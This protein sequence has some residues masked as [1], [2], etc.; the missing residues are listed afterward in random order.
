L[1]QAFHRNL[2]DL[3]DRWGKPEKAQPLLEQRLDFLRGSSGADSPATAGALA[4]L[5]SNLLAQ[6]K[7]AQAERALR[8][9]LRAREKTQPDEW[10]TFNTRSMLG[11]VLVGQKKYAEAGPLLL[12]GYQGLRK[13]Q[14]K[15]PP[16]VRA[17]R[18]KE[19]LQRLVRLCEATS[20][21]DGAAKW[22]KKLDEVMK[23]ATL[24]APKK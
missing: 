16:P 5:G 21:K 23:A 12:D 24:Q 20:N 22:Q 9:C 14:D 6:K 18:L 11:E 7:Q 10:T 2:A 1:T 8:D 4:E 13:R 3:Y 19:A 17:A 15:I